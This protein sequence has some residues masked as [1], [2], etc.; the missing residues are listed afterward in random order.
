MVCGIYQ[1]R[2]R[3]YERPE[4]VNETITELM[5]LD[6]DAR[7]VSFA[8]IKQNLPGL[9]AKVAA[10]LAPNDLDEGTFMVAI[11]DD[12]YDYGQTTL[13]QFGFRVYPRPKR[14]LFDYG[15]VIKRYKQ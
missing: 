15:F 6:R 4:V 11:V 10:R 5:A 1:V 2:R 7:E 13:D 8:N 14:T 12:D 9:A 3:R